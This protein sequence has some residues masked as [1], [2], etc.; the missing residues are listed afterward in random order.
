MD[1]NNNQDLA[2]ILVVLSIIKLMLEVAN[3]LMKLASRLL[4]WLLQKSTKQKDLKPKKP[5][6]HKR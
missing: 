5:R 6:K 3:E 2:T 1:I 4:D